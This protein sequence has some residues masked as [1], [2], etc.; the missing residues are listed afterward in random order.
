M[1]AIVG[2][3]NVYCRICGRVVKASES[4][5]RW[6]GIRTCDDNGCFENRHPLDMP[7]PKPRPEHKLPF[8]SPEPADREQT[9]TY[10]S[11]TDG[12]VPAG[13][14]DDNNGDI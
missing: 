14:F 3:W 12:E 1:P 7:Q 11:A 2:E 6:D 10:D 4:K 8:T 9:I 13:T 5:L